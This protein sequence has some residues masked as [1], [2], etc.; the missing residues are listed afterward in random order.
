MPCAHSK[1]APLSFEKKPHSQLSCR[2][3]LFCYSQ[4]VITID[5]LTRGSLTHS[6]PWPKNQVNDNLFHGVTLGHCRTLNVVFNSYYFSYFMFPLSI[7][8]RTRRT[9]CPVVL[10]KSVHHLSTGRLIPRLRIS[11]VEKWGRCMLSKARGWVPER[12]CPVDM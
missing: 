1:E 9:R 10:K 3:V 2:A 4:I 7:L 5:D 6:N 8:N 11:I 12:L